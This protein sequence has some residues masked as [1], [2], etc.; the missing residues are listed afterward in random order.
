MPSTDWKDFQ[1]N[2]GRKR[3]RRERRQVRLIE[4]GPAY[5]HFRIKKVDIIFID[6]NDGNGVG[7][8][9]GADYFHPEVPI[10]LYGEL[11]IEAEAFMRASRTHIRESKKRRKKN[12][13]PDPFQ[14]S[15]R[16]I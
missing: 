14:M 11:E 12:K 2:I 8:R 10:E 3:A 1:L 5:V 6:H 4:T 13:E 15:F 16:F 9:T 7:R